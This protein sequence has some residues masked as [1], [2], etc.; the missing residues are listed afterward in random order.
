MLIVASAAAQD[1][2][3][4][5]EA[6][7]AFAQASVDK[8]IK[9]AFLGSFDRN[10]VAFANGEP[11]A[12]YERWEKREEDLKPYAFWWP[13]YADIAASGDFGYTTGPVLTSRDRSAPATRGIYYASVWK[14]NSE[15]TWKVVA[16]HGS[17][18]YEGTDNVKALVTSSI[19]SKAVI[20][21]SAE[22]KKTLVDLDQS[23]N[24]KVNATSTHLDYNYF[25][26]EGRVH[27]LSV[28]PLITPQ[29]I[30]EYKADGK[31]A[32][33][34]TGGEVA[35]SNDMAVTHGKVKVTVVKDGKE[36][37]LPMC[38]M[39]VWKVL[40]GEWKLVLDVIS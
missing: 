5:F 20:K 40:N 35:S 21:P 37:V 1:L 31:F 17:A 16:D 38:Y 34:Q 22:A 24:N 14:K 29:A 2:E 23:Y 7:K 13:V 36:T 8:S 27:R 4:L 9:A 19:P 15:G 28:K 18:A 6:E 30:R 25:G 11:I 10:T 3:S 26:I 12:G 32:F 39:R 33:E